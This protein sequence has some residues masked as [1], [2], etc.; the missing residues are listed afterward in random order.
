M[1]DNFAFTTDAIRSAVTA[2]ATIINCPDTIGGTCYLQGQNYFVN[3]SIPGTVKTINIHGKLIAFGVTLVAGNAFSRKYPD[4]AN[5]FREA[6]DRRNK[7]PNI[8]P[9]DTNT[10][11]RNVYLKAQERNRLVAKLKIA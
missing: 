2:G 9:Y 1:G 11:S 10:L 3:N 7:L 5:S 4:I 6:N 8:H